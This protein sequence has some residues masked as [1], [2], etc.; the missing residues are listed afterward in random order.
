MAN[1]FI[2]DKKNVHEPLFRVEKRDSMPFWKN[3]VVY[4]SAIV[5]ALFL[6]SI[7]CSIASPKGNPIKFFVSLFEGGFGQSRNI[8]EMVK[9]M[10]LLVSVSM[11]LLPAFKMKF[12]NLGGNGQILMGGLAANICMF[13]LGGKMSEV[14]VIIISIISSILAGAIWAVIPAI[15]KAMFNANESLFT[16]MM[17]YISQSMV[18]LFIAI[19]VKGGSGVLKDEQLPYGRLPVVGNQFLLTILVG[20]V[21]FLFMFVFLKYTKKGYEIS[22]IGDSPNTAR[23][24]GINVKKSIIKTMIL[25]GAVC[26]IVGLMLTSGN[27]ANVAIGKDTAKN[28]GFTAIMATWLGNCNPLAILGTCALIAFINKGMT[29]VRIDFKMASSSFSNLV[30]GVIY[31]FIIACSFIIQ[32]RVIVRKK[33]KENKSI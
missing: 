11:A 23:Y 8:W 31:F 29:R 17:N 16:L 25:S 15:F 19:V 18:A 9:E 4:G 5:L 32:Y 20:A 21:I 13:C 3:A 1:S 30:V 6:G 33:K 12:W 10:A 7:I 14:L 26:G 28:M 24:V 2:E 27:Y 22:V